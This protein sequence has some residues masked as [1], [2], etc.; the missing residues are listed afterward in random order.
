MGLE[1]TDLEKSIL[2]TAVWFSLFSHPLTAFELWK[3]LLSPSRA[4][5]LGEV[6][7]VLEKSEWLAGRLEHFNGL[8]VLRGEMDVQACARERRK[9]FLDAERKYR[10][11]KRV[12]KFFS[13]LPCVCAVGAVNTLAWWATNNHSDIDLYIITRPGC[14]WSSRFWL[15]LPFALLGCRPP[16]NS[17]DETTALDSFCFSFFSTSNALQLEGV[18][19]PRDYYMSFWIKSIVPILDREDWFGEVDRLNKWSSKHLPNAR[20]RAQ[21]HRHHAFKFLSLPIQNSFFEPILRRLQHNRLPAELR[22]MANLDTRVI[23]TSEM[24]KFH[25]NDRRAEFRDSFERSLAKF[26]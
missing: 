15:V 6:Y 1:S 19:L 4:Y 16:K 10:A 2:R 12:A 8:Y 5:G 14:I 9:K 23:I 25:N 18:C 13:L 17:V 24:L 7:A 3:W 21:H 20:N 26:L 22:D 11:L